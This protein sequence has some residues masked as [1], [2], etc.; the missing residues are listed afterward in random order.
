MGHQSPMPGLA[1]KILSAFE[2]NFRA[3][4]DCKASGSCGRA[5]AFEITELVILMKINGLRCLECDFVA[6]AF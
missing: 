2:A 1:A 6:Q 3:D 5:I 4:V